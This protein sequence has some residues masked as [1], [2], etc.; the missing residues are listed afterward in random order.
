MTN[1]LVDITIQNKP[2]AQD[3]EGETIRRSLVSI[4]GF[5]M[6]HDVRS[7]KYLQMKVEAPSADE[8]Q[9]IVSKLCNDLR[10]FNPL[11]HTCTI[12][13]GGELP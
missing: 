7:G 8:A 9:R 10:I 6:V 3:P 12:K 13:V 2:L 1:Y 11:V 4:G 5:S